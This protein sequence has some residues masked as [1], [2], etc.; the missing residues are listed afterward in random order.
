[1]KLLSEKF[2]MKPAFV[3]HCGLAAVKPRAADDW[4]DDVKTRFTE[5]TTSEEQ[6][7]TC[8]FV[9]HDADTGRHLVSLKSAD[10]VDVCSLVDI[11]PDVSDSIDVPQIARHSISPGKHKVSSVCLNV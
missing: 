10:D 3:Y 8:R 2:C 6:V 1:M 5:L 11:P 4:A 9:S 7:F